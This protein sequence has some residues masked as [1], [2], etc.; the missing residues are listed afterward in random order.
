MTDHERT[1]ILPLWPTLG[2]MALVLLAMGRVLGNE[3]S[4]WDD[5]NTIYLNP[6]FN[7]P[8]FG[9]I[10]EFWDPRNI[11]AGLWVPLTYTVWGLL[12]T[13]A[14]LNQPDD[15]GSRLNPMVFHGASLLVHLVTTLLVFVLVRKLLSATDDDRP[16][17]W[18]ADVRA[19]IGAAVFAVH[20]IQVETVAWTSGLK[21]ALWGLW[22]AA[23]VVCYLRWME[24]SEANGSPRRRHGW[25]WAGLVCFVLGTWSKPTAMVIP[26]LVL[27]VDLVVRRQWRAAA[28]S[29]AGWF[30]IVP[31]VM[32]WTRYAQ[33]G[34]GVPTLSLPYRP[35]IVLDSLAFYLGKLVLPVGLTFDYGRTPL[36]IV[37][38]GAIYWTWVFPVAVGAA[39]VW[40]GRRAYSSGERS[41]ALPV[42]GAGWFVI[43]CSP[44]LG[45]IP[46]LFQYYSTVSDHYVYSSMVGVAI[47]VAWAAGRVGSA[48]KGTAVV[49][50]VALLGFWV[51]RSA[52]QMGT[53]R[54]STALYEHALKVN[55]RSFASM[56]NLGGMWLYKGDVAGGG[57]AGRADYKRA[58]VFYDS[59]V[60]TRD[61]YSVA[62]DFRAVALLRLGEREEGIRSLLKALD[63]ASKVP[64]GVRGP[65][66]VS[67]LM[68]GQYFVDNGRYA[69]A[70]RHLLA[71]EA[72][73]RELGTLPEAEQE[74]LR[75]LLERA[76]AGASSQPAGTR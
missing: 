69:D 35:L 74:K 52:Q 30:A 10:L 31:V 67:N 76:R 58:M 28:W 18:S 4:T 7:P 56:T 64:R 17:A 43:A 70:L 6:A 37:E 51:V 33:P 57:S 61:D 19:F 42:L 22:A 54:D 49:L 25:W 39:V 72:E 20:P 1:P 45:A 2:L 50:L 5:P 53:W 47:G 9:P 15:W 65:M 59:A 29:T 46:F 73:N 38:S 21:D 68:L 71:V 36:S 41:A 60:V 11:Q 62:W 66:M 48:G 32:L 55:P 26:A 3:F 16:R 75:G 63:V 44:V 34:G 14:Y 12:S 23:A 27:A 40:I 8:R 13:V 24:G